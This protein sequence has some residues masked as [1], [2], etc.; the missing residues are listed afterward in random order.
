MFMK[1]T[2]SIVLAVA[3]LFLVSVVAPAFAA[4]DVTVGSFLQEIAK[5]NNLPAQHSSDG[6]T[7]NPHRG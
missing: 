1:N 5:L 7:Q 2:K 4:A 6:H 3:I